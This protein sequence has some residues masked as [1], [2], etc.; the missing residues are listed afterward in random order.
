[1]FERILVPLDGSLC[2]EQTLPFAAH[3]AQTYH[4]AIVLTRIVDPLETVGISSIQASAT[5]NALREIQENEAQEYLQRIRSSQT[6]EQL[7][8]SIE[9]HSGDVATTLLEMINNLH[10][11]GNYKQP[12]PHRI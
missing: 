1:M 5:A 4:S 6:L 9:I 10:Q 2:A 3:I 11:P 8:T 7:E 12:W